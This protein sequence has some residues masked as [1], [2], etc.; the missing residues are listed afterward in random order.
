MATKAIKNLKQ[1]NNATMLA[2]V[3]NEASTEY[4]KRIPLAD[5]GEIAKTIQ[6]LD[7]YPDCWNELV[8]SLINR[9]GLVVM[10]TNSWTNPLKPLKKG[11]MEYGET[12]EEI[13]TNLIQ[14]VRY[15]PNECYTDVFACHEVETETAFH[16]INRQDM[17]QLTVNKMMLRRAFTTEY[18]LQEY[19]TQLMETPYTSDEYDEYLIM[20]NLFKLYDQTYGYYRVQVPVVSNPLA[21]DEIMAQAQAIAAAIE[22]LKFMFDFMKSEYN[23][24]KWP[25]SSR[26]YKIIVFATPRLAAVLN[27]YVI[28]F[29][30]RDTNAIDL[31][32]IPIDDFGIPGC[33][34]IMCDERHLMVYDTYMEFASIQNPKGRS[35]NYWWHHDGIYSLSKF[36]N[37]VMFTTEAGTVN[38]PSPTYTITAVTPAIAPAKD[39]AAPTFAPKGDEIRMTATVE[40]TTAPVGAD[41]PQ[42]VMWFVSGQTSQRTWIDNDGWLHVG[43]DEGA[44]KVTVKAVTPYRNADNP[45]GVSGTVDVGIGAAIAESA[46]SDEAA[47]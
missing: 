11:M 10:Q 40:G 15:D 41:V 36:V 12:I 19:I 1:V 5:Q 9:I 23:G 21:G 34:A 6:H 26:G 14:A 47:E 17:Y 24:L 16:S 42:A 22:E 13:R 45:E 28:P 8:T 46:A 7:Q 3:W 2:A 31:D 30:F 27:T 39:G 37:A 44:V 38:P 35:W 20:K 4:Q 43:A 29:A 33:E 25:T 18:G 32:I